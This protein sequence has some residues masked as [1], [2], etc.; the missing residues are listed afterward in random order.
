MCLA[1]AFVLVGNFYYHIL[2]MVF[3]IYLYLLSVIVFLEYRFVYYMCALPTK[4]RR[5]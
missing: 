4:A 1:L 2:N 3:K 5:H